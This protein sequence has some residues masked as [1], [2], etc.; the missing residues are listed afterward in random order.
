M[1]MQRFRQGVD[2]VTENP[3]P[4]ILNFQPADYIERSWV[5]GCWKADTMRRKDN[6]PNSVAVVQS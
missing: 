6:Y 1:T 4:E 2:Y 3:L 5:A